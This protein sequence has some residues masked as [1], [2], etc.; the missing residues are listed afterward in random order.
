VLGVE[1]MIGADIR[2]LV[3][4]EK[5]LGTSSVHTENEMIGRK[6]IM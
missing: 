5:T 6:L 1:G 4:S 3:T 2:M